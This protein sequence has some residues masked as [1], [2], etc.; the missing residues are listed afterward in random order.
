MNNL[1]SLQKYVSPCGDLWLGSF[2]EKLCLCEWALASRA[3]TLAR[4]QGVLH[5]QPAEQ[6]AGVLRMAAAQLDEYFARRRRL[7]DVPLLLLGTDFQKSVWRALCDIPYGSTCSYAEL[8]AAIR[9]PH[10]LRAVAAANRANAI[11][12]FVPCHRVIGKDHQLVG[13]G[14]GLDAKRHLIETERG[15]GDLFRSLS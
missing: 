8:A 6:S 10:A 11:S 15:C 4:A 9:K 13:Y 12:I 5:A 14:G 2:E 7:F 1:I 3:F